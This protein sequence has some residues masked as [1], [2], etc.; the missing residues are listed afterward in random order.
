MHPLPVQ[1][2]QQQQPAPP[3]KTEAAPDQAAVPPARVALPANLDLSAL[4]KLAAALGVG[5][6]KMPSA[7]A[8]AQPVL[9]QG[10]LHHLLGRASHTSVG[11][12]TW[13]SLSNL[14]LSHE[15]CHF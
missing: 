14:Q 9:S 15:H 6:V 2:Q 4:G 1:G 12:L 11:G 5:T 8:N 3:I 7:A 10:R 13:I